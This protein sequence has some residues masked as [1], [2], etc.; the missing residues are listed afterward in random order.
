S[1]VTNGIGTNPV[2]WVELFNPFATNASVA[3]MSLTDDLTQPRRWVFPA[4]AT[5]PARGY[6]VVTF[7]GDAPATTN[8][9]VSLNT[10]FGLHADGDRVYLFDS[11]ARAG[12]L[13]DSVI[14]GI[15]PEDFTI[16]RYPNA[17]G[18]WT[19]NVPTP[20]SAN[21]PRTLGSPSELRVNEWLANPTSG[22]EDWFELYNANPLPVA[23]GG[24]FLTD[25]P[26]DTTQYPIPPLSFIAG[27]GFV[28]FQADNA[29]ARG[30]NHTNFRLSG[31]GEW[32]AIYGPSDVL[33]DQVRFES[34]DRG[35]SEGRFPD[36]NP[37]TNF[38]RFPGTATPGGSNL[39]PLDSVIVNE[40]LTHTDPPLQD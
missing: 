26:P 5:V 30:A 4:G 29:P 2:D 17:T 27:N 16:G 10:G 6:L 23:L 31:S 38:V 33:I 12:V 21:L 24:L 25:L 1:S 8:N 13:L 36:G 18:G 39:L 35:V 9:G 28:Q 32:I 19:L 11:P 3:G 34:Q 37:G 40:V 7:N 15:Q 22:N 20:A 14:F